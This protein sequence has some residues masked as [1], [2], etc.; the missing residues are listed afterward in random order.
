MLNSGDVTVATTDG[1]LTQLTLSTHDTSTQ[2]ANDKDYTV[3]ENIL[4]KQLALQRY[5]DAW[6]TCVTINRKENWIKFAQHALKHLQIDTAIRVFRKIE[7]VSTVWSLQ[8]LANTEDYKLLAGH[9]ALFLNEYDKAEEWY[10]KSSQP[11]AALEMRRD[12]LQWD[13]AL[14]LA[15]RLDPSQISSIARE[16]A[17]QLEFM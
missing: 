2:N 14:H 11:T 9:V 12:L 1:T 5:N 4:N 8:N 17:Q 7:D 15:K 3:L 16:Y 10:L 6:H 13:Q